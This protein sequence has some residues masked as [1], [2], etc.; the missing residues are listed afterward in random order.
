M[1]PRDGHRSLVDRGPP[2]VANSRFAAAV[3][4]GKDYVPA[5]VRQQRN[6]ERR[7]ALRRQRP[8]GAARGQTLTTSPR[9]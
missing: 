6:R 7:G 3:E 2:L 4:G 8:Q 1:L 9:N 5:K